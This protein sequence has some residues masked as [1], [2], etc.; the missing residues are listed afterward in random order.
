MY[1]KTDSGV[2][3]TVEEVFILPGT[4]CC[5]TE[6]P[7]LSSHSSV[8]DLDDPFS[9]ISDLNIR[10]VCHVAEMQ[11]GVPH[12]SS[13]KP[14]KSSSSSVV[15]H[16]MNITDRFP[17]GTKVKAFVISVDFHVEKVAF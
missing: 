3:I 17:I 6:K 9:E 4:V 8:S 1:N 5:N 11:S 16:D 12:C 15:E 14:A 13:K 7:N 2:V 10:G